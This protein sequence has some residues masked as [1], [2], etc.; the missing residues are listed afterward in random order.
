MVAISSH[1]KPGII[2]VKV[3]LG[4]K[5]RKEGKNASRERKGKYTKGMGVVSGR[6]T[7]GRP[8]HCVG[9]QAF[10][11]TT[12]ILLCAQCAI[13]NHVPVLASLIFTGR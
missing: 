7:S 6:Q 8:L 2:S 1:N 5:W 13:L 11:T 9:T 4:G 12:S 3:T 10:L